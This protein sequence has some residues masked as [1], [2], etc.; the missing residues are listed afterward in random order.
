MNNLQNEDAAAIAG[1]EKRESRLESELRDVQARHVE[2][3][4]ELDRI[5]MAL[6]ALKGE[7]LPRRP[8][9]KARDSNGRGGLGDADALT[10]VRQSLAA[11]PKALEVLKQ[12]LLDHA[13]SR[14]LAGTGAH[15]V[16]RRILNSPEFK[17]S[18]DGRWEAA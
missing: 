6:A 3:R 15:L 18:A 7:P 10:V 13:R 5:Q 2:I 16:L 17:E 12:E 8:K 1:L 9:R 11:G 4:A 14:G